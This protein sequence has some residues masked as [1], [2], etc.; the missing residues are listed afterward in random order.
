MKRDKRNMAS[1]VV[2]VM[3]N[4]TADWTEWTTRN[5][6]ENG[7]KTSGWVYRAV[8]LIS[9]HI[10]S[11]PWG[12]YTAD[13][14]LIPDHPMTT[15]MRN[16]N[17]QFSSQ[18][19]FELITAWQQLS[20]EAYIK[21]LTGADDLVKEMYPISPD[22]LTPVVGKGV[23]LIDAYEEMKADGSKKR[24]TEFT[25][26]NI[27][28]IK[29]LD[30]ANPARGIGPLQVA[31]KAVD[32]DLDQLAWNKSAMQNRG[33]LDGVFTFDKILDSTQYS[34]IKQ[35][36]KE[37][38]SGPKNA[39]DIGVIGS[40]AK[41]QRLSLTP[42]EMD[43]ISSR[44]FNREEI[45]IIF[46]IPPQLAGVQ[47]ASTYNN[48]ATSMRIFWELTLIPILDDLKDTFNFS[49]GTELDGEAHI[50][51][52]VSGIP[53]LKQT[54]KEKAEISRVFHNMGV[55]VKALNE[56]F[57]LGVPEY[58]GW[59]ISALL[60]R[61]N[62]NERAEDNNGFSSDSDAR[63]SAEDVTK[64]SEEIQR[65]ME[66]AEGLMLAAMDES[67]VTRSAT[68]GAVIAQL[69]VGL[70][71]VAE[72]IVKNAEARSTLIDKIELNTLASIS[73]VIR[74]GTLEK[75]SVDSMK[76]TIVDLGIFSERR[77]ID[78][79]K[80]MFDGPYQGNL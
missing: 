43:F 22:R 14:K 66:K 36:I 41:Y 42:A 24:S 20:G 39:R 64:A 29:F 34:T 67:L 3:M 48:Y 60:L 56:M 5:A 58:E 7:Y 53:A 63:S 18:D 25:P 21:K 70:E 71:D 40:N 79:V 47:D 33:I 72:P 23:N 10:S 17:P 12:A 19:F 59:D 28:P 6:V 55:P 11:I 80:A 68:V 62:G 31:A 76:Q 57:A 38:F 50:D 27:I 46:G 75:K 1:S 26:E 69:K 65:M 4:P 30:P 35:K 54:H 32:I 16:P 77:S 44:R 45:F 52:D 74:D 9:R 78:I 2:D 15:L 8:S 61:Q 49:F 37:L 13:G 51:Y 73:E